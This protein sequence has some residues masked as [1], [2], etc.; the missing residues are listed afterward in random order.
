MTANLKSPCCFFPAF[1]RIRYGAGIKS[2]PAKKM[3]GHDKRIERE[4]VRPPLSEVGRQHPFRFI[5]F[6]FYTRIFL[7]L[8]ETCCVFAFTSSSSS[9]RQSRLIDEAYAEHRLEHCLS[10]DRK[11]MGMRIPSNLFFFLKKAK[12]DKSIY[13]N[14]SVETFVINHRPGSRQV[15]FSIFVSKVTEN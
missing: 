8:R 1:Y 4:F 13:E 10:A 7:L 5:T 15:K 2:C 6:C 3:A 9:S 11:L 14:S 12:K